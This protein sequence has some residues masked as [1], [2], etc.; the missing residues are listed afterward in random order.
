MQA[1]L[2]AAEAAEYLGLSE[3]YLAKLRMGTAREAGPN[4]LKIGQRAVRYRRQD[5]DLWMESKLRNQLTQTSSYKW[6]AL[7]LAVTDPRLRGKSAAVF[8]RL[9]DHH[10]AKTGLCFPSL[11]TLG[12]AL[13][14]EERTI[15]NALRALERN[16]YVQTRRRCNRFGTN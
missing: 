12:T 5:L 10:N 11:A 4:F 2:S 8:A 6:R 15:R 13:N 14:C 9:L 3:S 16:G 1:Y 7:Q